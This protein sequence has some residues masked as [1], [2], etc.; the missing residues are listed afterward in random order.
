MRWQCYDTGK[1]NC[2]ENK[3]IVEKERIDKYMV[4]KN[5]GV[6]VFIRWGIPVLPF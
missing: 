6:F 5:I 4:Q 2:I 1:C 3:A